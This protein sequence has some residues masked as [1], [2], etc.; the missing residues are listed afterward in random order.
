MPTPIKSDR[1]FEAMITSG[2]FR[3]G[4]RVRRVVI[5]LQAGETPI[6]H[7]ERY[8]DDRLLSVVP[9]LDGVEIRREGD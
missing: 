6:V 9:T 2:L 5:D 1:V 4:E 7:I 8:G 3:P